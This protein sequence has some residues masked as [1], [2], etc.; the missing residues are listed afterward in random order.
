MTTV[1][2][3]AEKK[4]ASPPAAE[5]DE[6]EDPSAKSNALLEP[7][8]MADEE[9]EPDSPASQTDGADDRQ[10]SSSQCNIFSCPKASS[11]QSSTS[12]GSSRAQSPVSFGFLHRQNMHGGGIFGEPQ[13]PQAILS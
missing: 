9:A 6:K 2:L 5:T 12:A 10:E 13:A 1:A 3:A 11:V 4:A 7:L 8:P